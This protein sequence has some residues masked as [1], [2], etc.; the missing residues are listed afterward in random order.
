MVVADEQDQ[1]IDDGMD[2]VDGSA[3]EGAAS[4][5]SSGAE[6]ASWRGSVKSCTPSLFTKKLNEPSVKPK[7]DS[8]LEKVSWNSGECCSKSIKGSDVIFAGEA[9]VLPFVEWVGELPFVD[10]IGESP[11]S[12]GTE[13]TASPALFFPTDAAN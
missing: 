12:D 9:N 11:F 2:A 3:V 5:G 1:R 10:P 13:E 7:P 6:I 4:D 8:R